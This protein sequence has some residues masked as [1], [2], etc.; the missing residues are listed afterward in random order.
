MVSEIHKLY[1]KP[2]L[3]YNTLSKY[4]TEFRVAAEIRN[5]TTTEVFFYS[6]KNFNLWPP[7]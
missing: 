3:E 2:P 7:T 5:I 1:Y 6:I 4:R